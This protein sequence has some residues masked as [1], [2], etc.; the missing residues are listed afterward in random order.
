[1]PELKVETWSIAECRHWLR[2][3]EHQ[4]DDAINKAEWLEWVRNKVTEL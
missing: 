4:R 2:W 3:I 1:M